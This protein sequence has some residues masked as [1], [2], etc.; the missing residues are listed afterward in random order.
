M[1]FHN[2]IFFAPGIAFQLEKIDEIKLKV[3]FFD[4]KNLQDILFAPGIT[5]QLEKVDE[6]TW[7]V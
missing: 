7:K 6:T 3:Y 1:C 5:F 4:P 2:I